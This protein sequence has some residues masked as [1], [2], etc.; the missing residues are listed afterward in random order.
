MVVNRI[1]SENKIDD[2]TN[3]SILSEKKNT[4]AMWCSMF[5]ICLVLDLFEI[6]LWILVSTDSKI[7]SES[8]CLTVQLKVFVVLNIFSLETLFWKIYLDVNELIGSVFCNVVWKKQNRMW[9]LIYN[10]YSHGMICAQN[11]EEWWLCCFWL[12]KGCR[13]NKDPSE[14][15]RR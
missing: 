7:F 4:A 12:L 1:I 8:L 15:S 6:L 2:N 3:F 11:N 13:I 10:W 5:L 14:T 9:W